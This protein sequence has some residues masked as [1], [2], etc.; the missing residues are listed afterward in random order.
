MRNKNL[1][2]H[3]VRTKGGIVRL[4]LEA[5]G[6]REAPQVRDQLLIFLNRGAK[7]LV[8]DLS[9][10]SVVCPCCAVPALVRAHRRARALGTAFKVIAPSSAA[11]RGPLDNARRTSPDP[12][13]V[14]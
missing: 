5:F 12:F 13:P 7:G 9:A 4:R 11:A 14:A 10:C 3:H 2:L 6:C 1:T 8:V